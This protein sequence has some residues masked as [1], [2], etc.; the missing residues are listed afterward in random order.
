VNGSFGLIY[1]G[2]ARPADW[3]NP[4]QTTGQ[5]ECKWVVKSMQ[6]LKDGRFAADR[7]RPAITL[8]MIH[9]HQS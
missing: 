6:L 9:R 8:P 5:V 4:M 7:G 3:S 1:T 2:Q